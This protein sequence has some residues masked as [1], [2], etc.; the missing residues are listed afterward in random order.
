MPKRPLRE[1]LLAARRHCSAETCLRLS[2]LIQVRLLAG[3]AYQRAHCVGLYSPFLNEVQ[4]ELVARRCLADRKRLVYPRVAGMT[5]QF[6]EVSGPEELVPGTYGIPEPSGQRLIAL[7]EIDLLVVP[8]V[9][10][11]LVGHRL[12]YGKGYYDRTLAVCK[13]GL[14]RVGFAYEFQVVEQLPAAAHDCRLTQLVTEQRLLR[15][16]N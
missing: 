14:E 4:T 2:G 7:E 15:F 16:A 10:F 11:D 5:L 12:G 3:E 9:A 13:P 1:K 6:V 8:G